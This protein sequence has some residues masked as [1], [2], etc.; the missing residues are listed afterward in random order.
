MAHCLFCEQWNYQFIPM[1][2]Q[3]A[4]GKL[5]STAYDGCHLNKIWKQTQGR[6]AGHTC[7]RFFSIG[8]WKAGS[9][10]LNVGRKFP[11]AAW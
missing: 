4:E 3:R 7:E 8:L 2:Q 9:L 11:V 10:T 5:P 6:A 1:H